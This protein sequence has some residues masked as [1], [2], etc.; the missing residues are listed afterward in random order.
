MK[1]NL[2]HF[3]MAVALFLATG[4]GANLLGIKWM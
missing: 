3:T 4:I 1:A 2:A